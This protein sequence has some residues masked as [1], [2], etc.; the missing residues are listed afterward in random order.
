MADQPPSIR[1]FG[2]SFKQFID[3][4]S[5]QV[6]AEEPFFRRRIADHFAA[7]P[8]TLTTVR[9]TFRSADQPNVQLALDEWLQ[10]H[11]EGCEML[12]ILTG[13]PFRYMGLH[14]SDL[15]ARP[16]FGR[17]AER[18]PVERVDVPIGIDRSLLCVDRALYLARTGEQPL[19][20]LQGGGR[21]LGHGGK[22]IQVEIMARSREEATR[23]LSDLRAAMRRHNVYRGHVVSLSVAEDRTL[24][25]NFHRLPPIAREDIVLPAGTLERIERNAIGFSEQRERLL[26]ARRHLKRGILLYGPPGTGKTLTAMHLAGRMGDRTVLLLTGRGQGLLDEACAM[27]RMLEPATVI[28]EDV[29]LIA[30]ERSPQRQC[31]NAMLFELLNQMDGLSDDADVLFLLTTNRPELLE[32]ALVARPGRVDLAVEIP[33]PDAACRHRLFDLYGRGL[34]LRADLDRFVT[35]S[36]GT[37]AAFIRELLRLA[38]VLS[39]QDGPEPVV[40]DRHLEQAMRELVLEGGPLM[41]RLLAAGAT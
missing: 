37:S 39:A 24:Q 21:D 7:D 31:A 2:A 41:R 11:K 8:A 9:A 12:G 22:T 5:T 3:Q 35:R 29:D 38:T 23:F 36:E 1:E 16:Q 14:L 19:A 25:V 10:A 17:A 34:V 6:S 15:I 32:P 40:A 30:E 20:V 13:E 26:A 28:L 4:M 18:G 33:L 27:A